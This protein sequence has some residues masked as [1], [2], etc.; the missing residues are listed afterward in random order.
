ME[1]ILDMGVSAEKIN[2]YTELV[3]KKHLDMTY[4]KNEDFLFSSLWKAS[5]EELRGNIAVFL[6][7]TS[8]SNRI[9]EQYEQAKH[10]ILMLKNKFFN[11][12][13]KAS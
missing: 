3:K 10:T 8:M 4:L 1:E 13:S 6:A 9:A 7:Q 11:S 5:E 2:N 12:S